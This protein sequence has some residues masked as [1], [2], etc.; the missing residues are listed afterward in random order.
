EVRAAG[1]DLLTV[2]VGP[3]VLAAS[4]S[5]SLAHTRRASLGTAAPPPP[6]PEPASPPESGDTPHAAG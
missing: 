2:R 5:G 4:K 1:E 6:P 3:L